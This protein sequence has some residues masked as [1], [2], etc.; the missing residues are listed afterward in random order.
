[1]P[2][3]FSAP[4]PF[5][6]QASR[7]TLVP[8]LELLGRLCLAQFDV[9]QRLQYLTCRLATAVAESNLRRHLLRRDDA[10]YAADEAELEERIA[11]LMEA[12]AEGMVNILGN[13]IEE[14]TQA[15]IHWVEDTFQ[16]LDTL[17]AP[18]L[19]LPFTAAPQT[20]SVAPAQAVA[21]K[22]AQ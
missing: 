17:A 19:Q 4:N 22:A 8:A 12:G 11:L 6:Q 10:Y 9:T 16:R 1:M 5:A 18:P 3:P 15:N 21:V 7:Q 20:L 2:A 13:Y 14:T